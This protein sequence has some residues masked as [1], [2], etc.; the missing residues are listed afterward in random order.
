VKA[1]RRPSNT[2]WALNRLSQ[3]R[4]A[5]VERLLA[6]GAELRAAQRDALEGGD[7]DRLRN[8]RRVHDEEVD[9]L[10]AAAER[11]LTEA[12]KPAGG[13]ARDRMSATLQAAASGEEARDLLLQGRLLHDLEPSGFGFADDAAGDLAASP[14]RPRAT[15]ARRP[16][17]RSERS[18]P[19]PSAEP[20]SDGD[21]AA[22]AREARR[23]ATAAER[24][25]ARAARTAREADDAEQSAVE[26]RRRADDARAAAIE[27]RRAADEA[28]ERN[29]RSGSVP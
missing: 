27:A 29:A 9:R 19:V 20:K 2:A 26:A 4:P 1:L 12:G 23:L 28:H 8:A 7:P 21:H 11:L 17:V 15:R 5:D 13:V 25:E 18:R 22:A 6:A 16:S 24:A 14:P 10:V 3:T